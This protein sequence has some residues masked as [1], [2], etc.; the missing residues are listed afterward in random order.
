M[1][2]HIIIAAAIEPEAFKLNKKLR[3]RGIFTEITTFEKVLKLKESPDL[4]IVVSKS[5]SSKAYAALLYAKARLTGTKTLL[6]GDAS[7]YTNVDIDS[8]ISYTIANKDNCISNK[9]I[10]ICGQNLSFAKYGYLTSDLSDTP[11]VYFRGTRLLLSDS[12]SQILHAVI[13]FSENFD[14]GY[15]PNSVIASCFCVLE[16]SVTSYAAGINQKARLLTGHN[17]LSHVRGKGCLLSES[18]TK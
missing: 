14:V 9:I 5:Y 8:V 15:V 12:E 10:D 18:V 1:Y 3:L 11:F 17:V 13:S 2:P 7:E 6:I 4:I 16:K